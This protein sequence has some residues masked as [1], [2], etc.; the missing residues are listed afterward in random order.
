[1]LLLL[2][3]P[4]RAFLVFEGV[5]SAFYCWLNGQ[6]VGYS[7]DS[8]L[9]AEFDVTELL[10][11]G[12]DNVL[13][14]KVLKWSDGSYLEDQDMW[15]LSGIHR[16]V[17]LLLK[18]RQH[19]ADFHTRTP[20]EWGPDG[21]LTSAK[22]EVEVQ[23]EADSSAALERLAVRAQLYRCNEAGEVDP[24]DAPSA[25]VAE[26]CS[27]L[28]PSWTAADTSGRRVGGEAFGGARAQ[29]RVCCLLH[30]CRCFPIP[31]GRGLPAAVRWAALLK[32]AGAYVSAAKVL[33]VTASGQP[34]SCRTAVLQHT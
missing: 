5:D 10:R 24:A 7:Q 15:W 3:S 19:I 30:F 28:Q 33:F 31:L 12:A 32:R 8:R 22:L 13:A 2:P 21:Q 6:F 23:V 26:A 9:P 17:Y 1:M 20:L 4:C 18:P 25:L 14:V 16:D 29:V 27:S 34:A 11:P